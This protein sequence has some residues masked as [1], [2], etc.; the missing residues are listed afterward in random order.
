MAPDCAWINA[1]HH[2]IGA[3]CTQWEIYDAYLEQFHVR[4]CFV[5]ILDDMI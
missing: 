1:H 2:S 5:Y 4:A 3:T